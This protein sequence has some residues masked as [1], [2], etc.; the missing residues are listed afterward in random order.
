MLIQRHFKHP[1]RA[2]AVDHRRHADIHA[3]LPQF[4]LQQRRHG[5]HHVLVVQNGVGNA[6]QAHADAVAGGA[7][8][9][10]NGISGITHMAVDIVHQ[11]LTVFMRGQKLF[12]RHA[13]NAGRA[14]GRNHAV[15]VFAYHIGIY[16]HRRHAESLA[17]I[18][19]QAR[20]VENRARADHT[21]FGQ[22]GKFPSGISEHVH[23]V[24]GHQKNAVKARAHHRADNAVEYLQII[25]NQIQPRFARPLRHTGANAH[26]IGI[27]AIGIIA[28]LD[29][30]GRLRIQ[31]AVLQI[32]HFAKRFFAVEVNQHHLIAMALIK[33]GK[34]IADAHRAGADNH[35]FIADFFGHNAAP[36]VFA[37]KI[38]R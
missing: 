10:D 6:A 22:A 20:R 34:C 28:Q 17:H 3:L 27:G 2:F 24:G 29:L 4:A 14:P 19:A 7:F 35:H 13:G 11:L 32:A 21:R 31:N 38:N 9:F 30:G 12:Q 18:I 33:H 25:I 15:A 16:A 36:I 23:R 37:I 1:H 26:N 8:G 5:Q